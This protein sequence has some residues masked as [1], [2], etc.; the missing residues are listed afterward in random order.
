LSYLLAVLASNPLHYWRLADPGGSLAFDI[1]SSSRSLVANAGTVQ[2]AYTGPSS[3]GGSAWFD[4]LAV[5]WDLDGEVVNQQCAIECWVWQHYRRGVLQDVFAFATAGG[6]TTA[7]LRLNAAGTASFF[8]AG[9]AVGTTVLSTQR[10]HHLVGVQTSVASILYV[11]GVQDALTPAAISGV[12]PGLLKTIGGASNGSGPT[13]GCSANIAE[14]AFYNAPISAGDVAAHYAAIEDQGNIP[15]WRAIG[16]F[17]QVLGTSSFTSAVAK[18][19]LAG[20]SRN[21]ANVP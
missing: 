8:G 17:D 19:L 12:S 4:A 11:D 10:W 3:N 2:F 21:W 16:S 15:T 1:G 9:A 6:A 5:C 18:Q 20:L 14:A 7:Q 13:N